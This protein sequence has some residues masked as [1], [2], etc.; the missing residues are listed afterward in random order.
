M[1]PPDNQT[2][3]QLRELITA[4]IE[5]RLLGKL[6]K[7]KEDE[8][9]KRQTLNE[10]HRL[11]NWVNNAAN[12]VRQ[13]QVVT[14]S[15]KPIHPDARGTNLYAPPDALPDHPFVGSHLLNDNFS[16]DVVGNAAALD[17]YKFLR[18]E[19][20]GKTLL[21]R[22]LSD[23]PNLAA[24]LS[25]D[26]KQ[27]QEWMSAFAGITQ[28]KDNHSSHNKAKQLYWLTGDNPADNQDFH[29]LAPLY[30]TSLAHSIFQAIQ[31]DR[32]GEQTKEARLARK[33][34]EYSEV[35]LHAYPGIALQKFGGTKPQNISQLNSERGGTNYLLHS[36]PPVWQSADI[37]KPLGVPS[38]FRLFQ[39]RPT[40]K[41]QIKGLLRFLESDPTPNVRTRAYRDAYIDAIIDE[42]ILFTAEL[43]AAEPGWS[44]DESC[45]L[46]REEQ[47]WLDPGRQ[48]SDDGFASEWE[49]GEWTGHVRHRF[50]AWLNGQLEKALPVSDTEYEYWSSQLKERLD[51]LE[52]AL[53]YV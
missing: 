28:P 3:T 14:H 29:L 33:N 11:S 38:A 36:L 37:R 13:L 40:V 32:F 46:P 52:E 31:E 48:A 39:Y 7:V 21:E 41:N 16:A 47:L 5:E 10:Q 4:F 12:R 35:E 20:D 8:H 19:L 23:D 30:G 22:A 25:D 53:P 42:L 44:N 18:L 6:E 34:N 43:T 9:E 17:V 1:S 50:A 24:A 45:Q 51:D 2:Q 49:S 15:L 26:P 27:S